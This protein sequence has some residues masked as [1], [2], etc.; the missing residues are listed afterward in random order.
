MDIRI[1]TL[2]IQ[3]FKGI[4]DRTF[5]L[6]GVSANIVGDN[7]LGKS[8]IF[9]AF[10]W[11]LFGKD[12]RNTVQNKFEIV[13]IDPVTG[14]Q[15]HHLETLVEAELSTDGIKTVLR[16]VWRETWSRAKKETESRL[17]GHESLFFVNGINVDTLENY[18]KAIADLVDEKIFRLITDPL[19]FIGDTTDKKARRAALMDLVGDGI[20]KTEIRARFADII[21]KMNGED[22]SEFRRRI[23]ADKRQTKKDL[24]ECDPK[25]S[26]YTDSLPA[27]EDYDAIAK[28]IQN[29]ALAA[30]EELA[31][32]QAE[33]KGVDE[34]VADIR[35]AD[36][37]AV[38]AVSDKRKKVADLRLAA[39]KLIDDA[40][41][42]VQS[43]NYDRTRNIDAAS[44]KVEQV[45]R[46]IADAEN[47][48]RN[49]ETTIAANR[50]ERA[51]IEA[52]VERMKQAIA[53][54]KT[55]AFEYNGNTVCPAC[56]QPLPADNIE[57][58]RAA[59]LEHFT[60]DNQRE[61]DNLKKTALSLQPRYDTLGANIE[62]DS[63]RA[64]LIRAELIKTR[65]SLSAAE[66]E[67]DEVKRTPI[68]NID[69]VVDNVKNSPE[70]KALEEEIAALETE[71]GNPV[72]TD[73][74]GLLARRRE[75]EE[76]CNV[77]RRDY[78]ATVDPLKARLAR[79]EE[80]ARIKAKIDA[81]QENKKRYT[82][83]LAELE[84]ME[85]D[86]AE[87]L[88]ADI[89]AVE[90]AINGL[91]R[92]ARF[93]MF[94]TLVNGDVVEDC[95]VMDT[96]NVPYGS[97]ND[98]KRILVGMD[99]IATFCRAH[100]VT[101]P[102]FVDNA[103]SITTSRFDVDSQVVRL[104]VVKGAELSIEQ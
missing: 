48:L 83:H 69:G 42:G 37:A 15:V 36:N 104:S 6:G 63:A 70:Y 35:K 8:T 24:A 31:A 11:L 2:K 68:F 52:R 38:A 59:A 79:R 33:I 10:T 56:G 71:I 4:Q 40:T 54:I 94:D 43:A 19:F 81:E 47:T 13:P 74:S 21:A 84:Q 67:L 29:R 58:A 27:P 61:I 20:D 45:R 103:E 73:V 66:Q 72:T 65:E 12:H 88:K 5:N 26:A 62:H 97:M 39:R 64:D 51:D 99:V 86:A 92:I 14:E 25:I 82:E 98:A 91:F 77:V 50:D 89:S 80:A 23:A 76:K 87:Y 93:R 100:G 41:N 18:S 7:G 34:Q 9:D 53:D 46:K 78:T 90:G 30:D 16:R 1:I 85:F 60:A 44:R 96:N 75:L 28:E 17:T 101:A 49:V 22:V 55:R 95:T 102:I 57:Q 3:N 32:I